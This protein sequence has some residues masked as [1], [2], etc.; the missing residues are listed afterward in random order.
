MSQPP[1]GLEAQGRTGA[2]SDLGPRHLSGYA[3]PAIC[4]CCACPVTGSLGPFS[5]SDGTPAAERPVRPPRQPLVTAA[6]T[7]SDPSAHPA[8]PVVPP[9]PAHSSSR[10]ASWPCRRRGC[11]TP[12][13]RRRPSRSPRAGPSCAICC[14]LRCTSLAGYTRT[15]ALRPRSVWSGQI[16]QREVSQGR[17]DV[18]GHDATS[19]RRNR[20]AA[21]TPSPARGWSGVPGFAGLGVSL[22]TATDRA[23]TCRQGAHQA[24]DRNRRLWDDT[25]AD[26]GARPCEQPPIPSVSSDRIPLPGH[27]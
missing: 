23:L 20:R 3:R 22:G 25:D 24:S 5:G 13:R 27:H 14:H 19:R 21:A 26:G 10:Q 15:C 9:Q 4:G 1:S 16:S 2:S 17:N 18:E 6:G 12:S 8:L 11:P 7:S